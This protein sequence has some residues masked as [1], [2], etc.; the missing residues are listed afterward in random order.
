MAPADRAGCA[1]TSRKETSVRTAAPEGISSTP[2]HR[3]D[4]G[5]PAVVFLHGIG[6]AARAWA[7]Q[8]AAFKAAGLHPV[9]LDLPGYGARPA[10]DTMDFEALAADLEATIERLGLRAACTR[11]SLHGRNDRADRDAPP[12]RRLLRG[13]ARRHQPRLR[14]FQGRVPEEVHRR[15]PGPAGGGRDHAGARGFDRRRHHG[16]QP[17]CERPCA[18]DRHH[19]GVRRPPPIARRSGAS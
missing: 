17:R 12:P 7:P 9:A 4:G 11:R 10:V 15:P 16:T 5:A 8:I 14:Q 13:G 3:H 6:G 1:R 19:G 2:L 18:R